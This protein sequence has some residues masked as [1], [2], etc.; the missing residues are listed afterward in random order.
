MVFVFVVM[1]A[2]LVLA[3]V[4]VSVASIVRNDPRHYGPVFLFDLDVERNLPGF[5]SWVLLLA[6]AA[7]SLQVSGRQHML[8]THM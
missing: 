6:N 7:L 8:A 1:A 3:H 2:C 4:V 5:L